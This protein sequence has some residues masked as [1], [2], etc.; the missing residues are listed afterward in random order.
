MRVK[1]NGIIVQVDHGTVRNGDLWECPKCE[2][3]NLYMT[4]K[5][6]YVTMVQTQNKIQIPKPIR[7]ALG[8]L[9]HGERVRVL[10]SKEDRHE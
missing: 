6:E 7:E 8:G 2:T 9:E 3:L 5:I 1:K 10:I 4:P